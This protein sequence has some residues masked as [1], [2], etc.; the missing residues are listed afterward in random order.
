MQVLPR[1]AHSHV[2]NVSAKKAEQENA[3]SSVGNLPNGVWFC[4]RLRD[5]KGCVELRRRVSAV[6]VRWYWVAG[7]VIGWEN[8]CLEAGAFR[9]DLKGFL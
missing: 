9:G 5:T 6:L 8:N 2:D 1:P 4:T 3:L 7:T